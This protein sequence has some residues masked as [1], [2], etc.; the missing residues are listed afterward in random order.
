MIWLLIAVGILGALA[1]I[2]MFLG[3]FVFV[4]ALTQEPE[5]YLDR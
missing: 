2:V 5:E 1:G 4:S 3:W